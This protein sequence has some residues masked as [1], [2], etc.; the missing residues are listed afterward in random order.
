MYDLPV[1]WVIYGLIDRLI[2]IISGNNDT[3]TT[4]K[5]IKPTPAASYQ[6]LIRMG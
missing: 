1:V 4:N 2:I 5:T 3:Q 6:F